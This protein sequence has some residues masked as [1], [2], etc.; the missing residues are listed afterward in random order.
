[1]GLR[2][3]GEVGEGGGEP[4][5]QRNN[6][7]SYLRSV[8]L[9]VALDF[10]KGIRTP[11]FLIFTKIS[12]HLTIFENQGKGNVTDSLPIPTLLLIASS[13]SSVYFSL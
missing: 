13:F 6:N 12:N 4:K 2:C 5:I 7:K 8:Y 9:P 10:S 3:V 1:M 11:I